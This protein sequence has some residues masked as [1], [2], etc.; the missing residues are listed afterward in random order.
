MAQSDDS[1]AANRAGRLSPSQ[2]TDLRD[3]LRNRN[4]GLWG[5][6]RSAWD[7]LTKDVSAGRVDAIEG[8]ISKRSWY[9]EDLLFHTPETVSTK[10]YRISVANRQDGKQ[11]FRAARNVYDSAPSAGWVRLF[12]LPLSRLVVDFEPLPHAPSEEL[13]PDGVRNVM[14]DAGAA[15]REHDEVGVSEAAA[16]MAS[17]EQSFQAFQ[18]EGPP[19]SAQRL[20]PSELAEAIV[21]MWSSPFMT[22]TF[23]AD[24]VV[25]A[26][27]AAAGDQT[28]RWSV[29]ADGRLHA[30]LMGGS[31]TAEAYIA[32]GWLTLGVDGQWF[33]L[34]RSA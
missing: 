5:R 34:Q 23:G 16:D 32:E 2:Q 13:T 20:D 9:G 17:I 6:I 27:M 11:A 10:S 18:A 7:P 1:L 4:S 30:A 33:R 28:G 15:R 29:G 21:G 22:V 24:G 8:A 14:R 25:T 19:S 26:R 12:Y 31:V 3:A